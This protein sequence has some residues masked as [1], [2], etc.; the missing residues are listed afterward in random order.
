MGEAF[1]DIEGALVV[2]GELDGH[3]LQ[4][5]RAFGPQIDDDVEDGAAHAAHELRLRGR[6][7]LEMHAADGALAAIVGDVALSDDRLEAM[8]SELFL[9]EGASEVAATVLFSIEIDD[10]C[11]P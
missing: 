11:A 2:P 10:E 7:I 9:A 4:V 8:R 1:G 3:V 5:G 6:R